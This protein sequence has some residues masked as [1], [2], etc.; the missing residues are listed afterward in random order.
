[1]GKVGGVGE[2]LGLKTDPVAGGV[3]GAGLARPGS[4]KVGGI[5]LDPRKGGGDLKRDP[6][7]GGVEPGEG[8]GIREKVVV[9][10][11][12]CQDGGDPQVQG[13]LHGEAGCPGQRGCTGRREG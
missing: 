4:E 7:N 6:R 11:L 10:D 2:E 3:V 13:P 1:M 5:E 9:K 8:G 12:A